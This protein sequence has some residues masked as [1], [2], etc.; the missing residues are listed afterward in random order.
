MIDP[1]DHKPDKPQFIHHNDADNCGMST[2]LNPVQKYMLR[3]VLSG[4]GS[5]T[6]Q[7]KNRICEVAETHDQLRQLL[8]IIDEDLSESKPEP[9]WVPRR[10]A[11][12]KQL[13]RERIRRQYTSGV[14]VAFSGLHYTGQARPVGVSVP[15]ERIYREVPPATRQFL[16]L[17]GKPESRLICTA[18]WE[19]RLMSVFTRL[20]NLKRLLRQQR[21]QKKREFV[22]GLVIETL[23]RSQMGNERVAAVYDVLVGGVALA[24]A[25]QRRRLN[26]AHLRQVVSRIVRRVRP[27]LEVQLRAWEAQEDVS[28]TTAEIG[29]LESEKVEMLN[30][31]P[32]EKEEWVPVVGAENMG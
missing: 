7:Y 8:P 2:A 16:R 9:F 20:D 12:R 15:L 17:L 30:P 22:E 5:K 6:I 26:E 4:A 10:P 25:A 11:A 19:T 23:R 3:L 18:A 13:R 31:S 24:S 32:N 21:N 14:R 29:V 1:R 27:L 28:E